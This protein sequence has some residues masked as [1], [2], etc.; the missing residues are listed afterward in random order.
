MNT[1]LPFIVKK[2]GQRHTSLQQHDTE[3]G[4]GGCTFVH[5]HVVNVARERQRLGEQGGRRV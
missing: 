1:V 5:G 4:D 2:G 3:G